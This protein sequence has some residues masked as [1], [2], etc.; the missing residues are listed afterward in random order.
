MLK[1]IKDTLE[2]KNGHY[3]EKVLQF[4]EGNFL[5]AFVDWMI[6]EANDKGL[7]DGSI[8]LVQPINMGMVNMINDQDGL[9]TLVMRGLED[10][11]K[12][13]KVKAI[14]SVSRGINPFEDY[15]SYIKLAE[16]EDLKIIVSNT[17]E[18]GI[19]YVEGDRFEDKLPK[20]FPAKIT[21][22]LHHRYTHFKGAEDKGILLLPV[23]LIDNNGPELKRIVM[24]YAKEWNLEPA[25]ISWMEN[26]CT[27]ANTLV[28]RIVTGYPREEAAAYNEKFGY[29]DN[30]MVTSEVFNLWVIEADKKYADLLPIAQTSANVIWT[31]DVRP[32]KKRKV[33]I[34]NG[35][36]TST[37]LAAYLSG[38]DYVGQF[39]DD[40]DFNAFLKSLIFDEVIPTIDLPKGELKEFAD[41]V[42]ERFG[43]PYIKHRLL[44]ISLNSVSKFTARCLPSLLDYKERTGKLPERMTYAL[45]ALLKFYDIRKDETGYFGTR[46]NNDKYPVKDDEKNLEFFAGIWQEKDLSVLVKETLMNESLWHEDLTKVEGL[47]DEVLKHLTDIVR[48][49]TKESLKKLGKE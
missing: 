43:N 21:S 19:S 12:T 34:L 25:F 49:G 37:V 27:F 47:Y 4:G 24:Q 29:E 20:A 3:K 26:S 22:F 14:T 23:E 6:D 8:V 10:G 5:R 18:A 44:D 30:L 28:D 46:E 7:F 45:A 41:A 36:H 9:Y 15:E 2:K 17:T 42:F 13:E 39:I 40:A 31:D 33:R 38:Y 11:Q 32:Y 48:N 1:N 16:S 35:A